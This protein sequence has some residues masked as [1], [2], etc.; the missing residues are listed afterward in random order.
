MSQAG[1]IG[2]CYGRRARA[3][4][5]HCASYIGKTAGHRFEPMACGLKLLNSLTGAVLHRERLVGLP[6]LATTS[7]EADRSDADQ[8]E[9]RRLGHS[10]RYNVAGLEN[11]AAALHL[12]VER[13]IL[14]Q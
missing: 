11:H 12:P 5:Q 13:Q 14:S 8:S 4:N 3:S 10:Q 9:R 7:Q 1:G 2:G 6:G